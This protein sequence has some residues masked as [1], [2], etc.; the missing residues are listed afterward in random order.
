MRSFFPAAFLIAAS[1]SPAFAAG[2]NGEPRYLV[3]AW[4]QKF[5]KSFEHGT[6]WCGNDDVCTLKVG[7]HE[8]RLHFFLTGNSYRL[9][10]YADPDDPAPC[11]VFAD[12]TEEAFIDG[13]TPH[14]E[15]LYYRV[16]LELAHK[17]PVEFGTIYI[18]LEDLR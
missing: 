14:T 1:F 18:A 12:R 6:S 17:G 2:Q 13:G 3:K 7:Q 11:C 15:V 5:D 4:I 16:P 9:S 10:V 8:V